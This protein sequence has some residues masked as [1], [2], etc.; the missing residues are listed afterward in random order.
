MLT[1]RALDRSADIMQ[2]V[3]PGLCQSR[4]LSRLYV[5]SIVLTPQFAL[6][7]IKRRARVA[8][9]AREPSSDDGGSYDDDEA[10]L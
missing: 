3:W 8:R 4:L 9:V 2:R 6:V 7:Q 1:R 5:L 10:A